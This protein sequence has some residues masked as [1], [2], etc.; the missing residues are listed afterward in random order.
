[1]SYVI[2]LVLLAALAVAHVGTARA[3][4]RGQRELDAVRRLAETEVTVDLRSYD[5]T[6]IRAEIG[7][8]ALALG[9]GIEQRERNDRRIEATVR[10]AQKELREHGLE[11][12]GLDAEAHELRLIDAAGGEEEFV[13][14]VPDNVER[15]QDDNLP[16]GI[17]GMTKGQRRELMNRRQSG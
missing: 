2:L 8:L 3:V 12:A 5:D 1:M 4:L 11:H 16:S 17:P 13:Q 6:L 10:R 15:H 14:D 9:E 7:R